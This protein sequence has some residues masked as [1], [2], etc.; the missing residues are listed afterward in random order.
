ML[1]SEQYELPGLVSPIKHSGIQVCAKCQTSSPLISPCRQQT[2]NHTST[3]VRKLGPVL[4]GTE[5]QVILGPPS[6]RQAHMGGGYGIVREGYPTLVLGR[7]QQSSSAG[8]VPPPNS[9]LQAGPFAFCVSR[10]LPGEKN[11]QEISFP[12]ICA[13]PQE[14]LGQIPKDQSKPPRVN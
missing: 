2:R 4:K 1:P 12:A 7:K 9:V 3:G 13:Y 11:L 6:K 8:T 10:R 5:R 14:K